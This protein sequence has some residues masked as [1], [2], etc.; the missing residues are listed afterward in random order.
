M[1]KLSNESLLLIK[2]WDAYQDIL[3]AKKGLEYDFA[4]LLGS[5]VGRLQK[6]DWWEKN[7]WAVWQDGIDFSFS[8][9][10]WLV[11]D[12]H[13]ILV[14]LDGFTPDRVIGDS[15]HPPLLNVWVKDKI[16][17]LNAELH[18]IITQNGKLVI[19][20][21]SSS[22]SDQTIV[23]NNLNSC[24]PE[25]IDTLEETAFNQLSEFCRNYA[26]L[27]DEFDKVAQKYLKKG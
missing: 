11:G 20:G 1:M 27:F 16:P 25:E 9:H 8:D 13:L 14:A 17:E 21:L 15:Q 23:R 3:L 2:N 7:E 4:K 12:N 6:Q 24:L 19:D 18:K 26:Q 10:R 22:V 5:L